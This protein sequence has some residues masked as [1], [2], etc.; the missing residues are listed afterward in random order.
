MDAY[1]KLS[2]DPEALAKIGSQL[3]EIE[4]GGGSAGEK[5]KKTQDLIRGTLGQSVVDDKRK[6]S[7]ENIKDAE[8]KLQADLEAQEAKKAG[9]GAKEGAAGE[10]GGLGAAMAGLIPEEFQKAIMSIAASLA[11]MA[12]KPDN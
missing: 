11:T 5:E 1:E 7:E 6:R 2:K 4:K 3:D 9:G 10:G 8:V 12:G